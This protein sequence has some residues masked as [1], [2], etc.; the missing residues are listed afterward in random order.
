MAFRVDWIL[1]IKP[2][3]GRVLP[4]RSLRAKMSAGANAR[5]Y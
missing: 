3:T 4:A 5:S 2:E 1:D